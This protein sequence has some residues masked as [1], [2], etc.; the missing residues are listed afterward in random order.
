MYAG[1]IADSAAVVV[2]LALVTREMKRM[3]HVDEP[4]GGRY[5][6]VA[7]SSGGGHCGRHHR[8]SL[9][10]L[11]SANRPIPYSF[12]DTG[13][14]GRWPR[15]AVPAAGIWGCHPGF[16]GCCVDHMLFPE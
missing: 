2:A 14:I 10:P 3:P 1:P 9:R 16:S 8:Q 11:G 13:T 12:L 7:G 4:V 15:A 6:G 5:A